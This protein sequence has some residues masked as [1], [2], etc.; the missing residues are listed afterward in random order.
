MYKLK[1]RQYFLLLILIQFMILFKSC[2][3]VIDGILIFENM[4]SSNVH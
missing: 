1:Q 4:A 3:M 2:L